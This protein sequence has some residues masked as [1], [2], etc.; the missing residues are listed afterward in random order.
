MTGPDTRTWVVAWH[1]QTGSDL[2]IRSHLNLP[3]RQA[4]IHNKRH[5]GQCAGPMSAIRNVEL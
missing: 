3:E 2:V 5:Y 4:P 1:K